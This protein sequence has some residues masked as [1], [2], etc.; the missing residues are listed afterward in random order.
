MI[1]CLI[2]EKQLRVVVVVQQLNPAYSYN[3]LKMSWKQE[4]QLHCIPVTF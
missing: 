1:G 2:V 3:A 4:M